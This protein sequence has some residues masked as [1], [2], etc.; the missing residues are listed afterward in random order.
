MSKQ[1]NKIRAPHLKL[2]ELGEEIVVD[3]LEITQHEIL[4]RNWRTGKAE[5]DIIAKTNDNTL[6]FIEVKTRS[7]KDFGLGSQSIGKR[8]KQLILDAAV[9]Y[10]N[11]N[12]HQGELRFDVANV[13]INEKEEVIL[14]YAPD[15]FFDEF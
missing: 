11:L 15:A 4:E 8:K 13:F 5:V 7:S 6:L 10:S 9:I 1:D 3:F 2:G 12:N 14:E